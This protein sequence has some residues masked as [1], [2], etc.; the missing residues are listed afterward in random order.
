MFDSPYYEKG[1]VANHVMANKPCFGEVKQSQGLPRLEKRCHCEGAL[2]PEAIS[3]IATLLSSVV[4]RN[5]FTHFV[6][7][8]VRKHPKQSQGLPRLRFAQA[9]NDRKNGWLAR[10]DKKAL[11]MTKNLGMRK[12][13]SS[14]ALTKGSAACRDDK[15]K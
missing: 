6:I 9:R 7:A 3:G 11:G 1:V 8:R 14:L 12:K 2:A 15:K 13:A 5:D 4:A 10:D